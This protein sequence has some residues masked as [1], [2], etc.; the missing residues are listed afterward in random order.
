VEEKFIGVGFANDPCGGCHYQDIGVAFNL[1]T[2]G[3]AIV[4]MALAI[5][6]LRIIWA[7]GLVLAV[8]LCLI[9]LNEKMFFYEPPIWLFLLFAATGWQRL[10]S[11][12][13]A[14]E[15]TASAGASN[16]LQA[17]VARGLR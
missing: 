3:G 7:N 9:P 12:A 6:V 13:T 5:L 8:I 10:R 4:I 16:G 15:K 2:R 14:R 11:P 17:G 1:I